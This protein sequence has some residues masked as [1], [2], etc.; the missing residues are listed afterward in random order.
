MRFDAATACC[1]AN[2]DVEETTELTTT[3]TPATAK[4]QTERQRRREATAQR[5]RMA[6]IEKRRQEEERA[7]KM[8]P[9]IQREAVIGHDGIVLRGPR[10]ETDG[11]IVRRRNPVSHL[12]A[13]WKNKPDPLFRKAH[14]D[15]ADRL[16]VA[17]EEGAAGIGPGAVNYGE[18]TSGGGDNSGMIAERVL[19]VIMRQNKARLE[20]VAVQT[21]LGALW[22]IVYRVVICGVELATVAAEADIDPKFA[23]GYLV[24]SLDRLVEHYQPEPERRSRI[25]SIEFA[26][27]TLDDVGMSR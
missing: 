9:K 5:K 11:P 6:A 16:L 19:S 20:I 4:R 21:F 2:A 14:E 27:M 15:A 1:L 18:R 7:E 22:P 13:R 3:K 17:W 12:V 8:A 23:S 24:A 25:R 10:L 26:G